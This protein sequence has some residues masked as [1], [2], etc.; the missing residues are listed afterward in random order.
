[1][2]P[3]CWALTRSRVQLPAAP[4]TAARQ[5]P[6][7]VGFSSKSPGVGCRASLQGL[8]PTQGLSPESPASPALEADS[9]PGVHQGGL[10]CTCICHIEGGREVP[11]LLPGIGLRQPP[12]KA[13][14][15]SQQVRD[16]SE[17]P[18]GQRRARISAKS[19][20]W[21]RSVSAQ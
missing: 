19:Q 13:Q 21:E 16:P 1:M 2:T 10:M 5:A 14:I 17:K 6:L 20:G 12:G 18:A 15:C 3:V 8:L 7:S 11:A 4:Q 9:L